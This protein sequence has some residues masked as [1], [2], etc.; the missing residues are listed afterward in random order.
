[1]YNTSIFLFLW[2]HIKPYKWYYV[3][4]LTAPVIGAIF[5]FCYH[6]SIKLFVD[7]MSTEDITNYNDVIFPIALFILSQVIME[8]SW[9]VSNVLEWIA[10]PQVRKSLLLKSYD[11]VQHHSYNF[12]QDNFTGAISSKIKGIL[13]GYDHFWAEMH[14]GLSQRV[15]KII[16]SFVILATI[17]ANLSLFLCGWSILYFPIMYKLSIKLNQVSFA[18]TNIRHNLIG[19]ISDKISNIIAVMSFSARRIELQKLDNQI[20]REFIPKQLALYKHNFVSNVISGIFFLIMTTFF[21]FYMV[22]LRKNG[23]VTIGDFTFVFAI[24]VVIIDETWAITLSMLDFARIIGDLRSSI[25]LLYTPQTNIDKHNAKILTIKKPTIEFKDISF[26]YEEKNEVFNNLNLTIKAGEKIGLIGYSGA[27]KSSLVN[28][29]L[30]YFKATQGQILIDGQNIDDVIQDSLREHIAVIPQDTILFHRSLLE[31]IRYGRMSASDEEVIEASKA[32]H[33]HDFILSLPEQ[34]QTYV[35]ERGVKLSGGQRQRVSIARAIL[36]DAPILILDEATSALDSHT[37]K[38]IQDSINSLIESQ[39]KT[40][41]AIAHRLSTL[42]HMDR[43]IVMDKGKIIE[44]G[45][46]DE[47]L[48]SHKS[49]YKKLWQIQEM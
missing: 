17:N 32:A 39:G 6:Y 20:S 15:L 26:G 13:D 30:R 7:I 48:L 46:H 4:M 22:Y 3:G 45:D 19:Q 2:Q 35:G 16:I 33:I 23:L 36:K 41:I 1:M 49:L 14:H 25:S 37:E 43:V 38:L 47:L 29:L 10:E 28:L 5:P 27:G 24:T 42:K 12:F 11:Y 18:E 40:V 21:L 9:R 8:A 34:Y 44:E 31:N